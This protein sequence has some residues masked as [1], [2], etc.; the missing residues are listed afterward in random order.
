MEQ[1]TPTIIA[2]PMMDDADATRYPEEEGYGA[3]SL[4][5][6]PNLSDG[7]S[8][9]D[10]C[11]TCTE[12]SLLV[13]DDDDD[14]DWSSI[15]SA[16]T[17]S[18]LSDLLDDDDEEEEMLLEDDNASGCSSCSFVLIPN[19]KN[20]SGDHDTAACD[21]NN[22]QQAAKSKSK[23]KSVQ[24][25][26]VDVREY[27]ICIGE[28]SEHYPLIGPPLRLDWAYNTQEKTVSIH[29]YEQ[30]RRRNKRELQRLNA[31]QR[32]SLLIRIGGYTDF[33]FDKAAEAAVSTVDRI[34]TKTGSSSNKSNSKAG[35]V[36]R[37]HSFLVDL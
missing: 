5:I 21:N 12:L 8:T 35:F 36:R 32:M 10:T 13:S 7:K 27:A 2:V 30:R 24:F 1:P 19:N 17:S 29:E 18:A 22:H 16:S 37:R 26:H 4:L 15:S 6:H 25:S 34:Q 31:I 28:Q 14:D 3:T 23:K 33:D 9:L 20:K 11:S